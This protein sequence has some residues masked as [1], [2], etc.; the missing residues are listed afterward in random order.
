MSKPEESEFE[1]LLDALID[2]E[3]EAAER[4]ILL[5]KAAQDPALGLKLAAAMELQQALAGLP[6]H[7]AP[8]SLS[9]KLHQIPQRE[10]RWL[11]GWLAQPRWAFAA[12]LV[13][14]LLGGRELY[15]QNQLQMQ[16]QAELVQAQQDLALVLAYLNK[17]NR[18]ASSQIQTTLNAA[19]AQPVAR[20]TTQTLQN[21]LQPRPEI[22][23]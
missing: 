22:E 3:L 12:T 8:A 4:Q 10:S 18:S 17:V 16:Q 14:C 2:G 20:I 9:R 7:Q 21:P 5:S 11:P 1:Q 13:L 6:E 15:Q 23:L 19:T